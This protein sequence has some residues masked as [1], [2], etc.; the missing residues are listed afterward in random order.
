MTGQRVQVTAA[1]D[2]APFFFNSLG[3]GVYLAYYLEDTLI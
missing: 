1:I 3:N 2:L